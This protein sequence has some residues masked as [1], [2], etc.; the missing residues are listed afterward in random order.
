MRS[1]ILLAQW[2]CCAA[3]L[4]W[5]LA[6]IRRAACGKKNIK[7]K[8]FFELHRLDCQFAAEC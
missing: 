2:S 8:S 1:S 7:E 6:R 5:S 3:G 4:S